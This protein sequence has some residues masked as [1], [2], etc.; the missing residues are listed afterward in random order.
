[1]LGAGNAAV[2]VARILAQHADDLLDTDTTDNVHRGLAAK[3][4]TDVHV[5]ARRGI[6]QA[7]FTPWNC[8]NSASSPEWW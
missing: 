4:I 6:A 3:R 1:M 7:K 8:G 2:D 5:F